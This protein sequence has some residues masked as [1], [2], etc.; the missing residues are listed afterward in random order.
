MP[1]RESRLKLEDAARVSCSDDVSFE[2]RNEFGFAIT[3]RFGCV[4]LHEIVDSR[5]AAAD[6][7]LGDLG[8]FESGNTRE[9]RSR[10]RAH[11]LRMLQ[12]ARVVECHA[13]F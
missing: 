6:G 11:A 5:G 9:Q 12:M 8:E 3:E 13:Q 4:G 10:L 2:L 7:G 1:V